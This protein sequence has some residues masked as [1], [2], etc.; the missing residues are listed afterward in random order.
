MPNAS[1]LLCVAAVTLVSCSREN[2]TSD[3]PARPVP[4]KASAGAAA[5]AAF[6]HPAAARLVA[7]GDLHGDLAATRAALRLAG[8][9][10]ASDRWIG[11]DLVI[12]QT[13]DQ[14]DR[15]DD[16]REI[17]DLFDR[18]SAE[19]NAAGGRVIALNGNHEVM[20]VQGDFRYVTARGFL[21][22]EGVSPQS[23]HASGVSERERQRAAAFLPGGE[24]AA[25][26]AKRDVIAVVGDT[27][28]VHG[29]V[30][31]EHADYGVGRINA[32][33]KTWMAGTA[34]AAP[35]SVASPR[36]PIWIRDYSEPV[37]SAA[38][39]E[40]LG[41]ALRALDAKRMVVGHTV[42]KTGINGACDDRVFRIDV[43]LARYYGDNAVE[44]LEIAGGT[45]R[46]L[47][48]RD[49]PLVPPAGSLPRVREAAERRPP[50]SP[51]AP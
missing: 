27:V 8:A 38:A 46:V 30:L 9:I 22:F 28:F 36:A 43:G 14:L 35:A 18:L 42:Q 6:R 16:E 47:R 17:L 44:V 19:A 50:P 33:A 20:N 40:V 13:G 24:Y 10:D 4:P 49:A 21:T 39:C 7:I 23:P 37:P 3:A 41:R 26:L 2:A 1:S 15:G 31:P 45:T 48:D 5:P 12:V 11:A 34:R 29:G 51:P 25:R 32:E